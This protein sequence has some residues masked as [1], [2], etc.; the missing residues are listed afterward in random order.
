MSN[1]SPHQ[2]PLYH[3]TSHPI[4]G[5]HIIPGADIGHSGWGDTGGDL[6]DE[7]SEDHA[8]ATPSEKVAWGYA[9]FSSTQ[10]DDWR[11]AGK[12]PA[13]RPRVH[14]VAPNAHMSEGKTWTIADH[15]HQEF[16]AP[17]FEK[18]GT[19]H[20]IMPGRQGTFPNINWAQFHRD[21]GSATRVFGMD[22]EHL[23]EDPNHP[24]HPP[25][26]EETGGREIPNMRPKSHP[27]LPLGDVAV[28]QWDGKIARQS[29]DEA[30]K[31]RTTLHDRPFNTVTPASHMP[32]HRAKYPNVVTR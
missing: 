8:W 16:K 31:D 9:L 3:G 26:A 15:G 10:H 17:S 4:E 28:K 22:E 21:P 12:D 27:T 14:E 25:M 30:V 19:V 11:S 18:T 24:A 23:M 2:F 13:M 7:A 20:D 5:N 6:H 29:V 1:L 32:E